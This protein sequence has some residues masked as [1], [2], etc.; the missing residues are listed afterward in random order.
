[1]DIQQKVAIRLSELCRFYEVSPK[2]LSKKTG[3]AVSSIQA[4]LDGSYKLLR[5]N[6]LIKLCDGLGISLFDFF[7]A[8]VFELDS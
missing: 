4:I 7:S 3:V 6:T 2:E 5:I 1:M 8:D